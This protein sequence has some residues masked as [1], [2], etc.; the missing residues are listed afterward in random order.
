MFDRFKKGATSHDLDE[1]AFT[2]IEDA[3]PDVWDGDDGD[4]AELIGFPGHGVDPALVREH[5]KETD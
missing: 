1:V 5:E 2:S 3:E 4:N